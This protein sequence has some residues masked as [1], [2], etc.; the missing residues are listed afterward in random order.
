MRAAR[1]S[2]PLR[3]LAEIL[4]GDLLER[5]EAVALGAVIDEAGLE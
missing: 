3:G 1:T 2:P 5:Q 4:L